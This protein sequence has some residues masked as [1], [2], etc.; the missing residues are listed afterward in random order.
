MFIKCSSLNKENIIAEDNRIFESFSK[1]SNKSD[2]C[3]II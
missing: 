2:D 1:C 3:N